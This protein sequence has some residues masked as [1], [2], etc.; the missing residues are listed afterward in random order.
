MPTDRPTAEEL[1][2]AVRQHLIE[3]VA[4]LL[5]GQPA[6]HLRVATNAL[7]IIGR[8]MAE[9][10]DMDAAELARLQALLDLDDRDTDDDLIK[11]N[12]QL[13]ARIKSDQLG[14]SRGAVLEHLRQT[15]TDKLYLANPRYM[16]SRD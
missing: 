1:L 6:F 15:A 14:E 7:A 9:G 5:H 12:R 16:T 8:T 4:P 2:L 13:S 11:L 3:H 10:A